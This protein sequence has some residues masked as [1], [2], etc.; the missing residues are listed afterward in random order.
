LTSEEKLGTHSP[1]LKRVPIKEISAPCTSSVWDSGAKVEANSDKVSSSS[2][3]VTL[4][5][6]IVIPVNFAF[7]GYFSLHVDSDSTINWVDY[8]ID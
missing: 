8:Y 4:E 3:V 7:K 2:E 1:S 6:K 5:K